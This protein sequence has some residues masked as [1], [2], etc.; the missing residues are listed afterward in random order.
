MRKFSHR[1]GEP[2]GGSLRAIV[3][4]F[5]HHKRTLRFVAIVALSLLYWLQSAPSYD[6]DGLRVLS[7]RSLPAFLMIFRVAFVVVLFAVV[8]L[9]KGYLLSSEEQFAESL[10]KRKHRTLARTL[11]SIQPTP[12]QEAIFLALFL[13]ALLAGG[14]HVRTDL[15]G[16]KGFVLVTWLYE[17]VLRRRHSAST[18][19]QLVCAVA[20][21]LHLAKVLGIHDQNLAHLTLHTTLEFA[22]SL[23]FLPAVCVAVGAASLLL[24]FINFIAKLFFHSRH[25]SRI[26]STPIVFSHPLLWLLLS[27]QDIIVKYLFRA[28]TIASIFICYEQ[29]VRHGQLRSIPPTIGF[30]LV[31]TAGIFL[32]LLG[33]RRSDNAI[34]KQMVLASKTDSLDTL[35][36]CRRQDLQPGMYAL[37]RRGAEVPGTCVVRGLVD[38]N[39]PLSWY[40][41]SRLEFQ[42][43]IVTRIDRTEPGQALIS[44]RL[45]DGESNDKDRYVSSTSLGALL[46]T[47]PSG[48]T[49][50]GTMLSGPRLPD[51]SMFARHINV[52][53]QG[54]Q[55]SHSQRRP[56]WVEFFGFVTPSRMQA[57]PTFV[58]GWLR[59][60]GTSV[61]LGMLALFTLHACV[62]AGYF[63]RPLNWDTLVETFLICQVCIPLSLPAIV[64]TVLSLTQPSGP[65]RY[66][67]A[68]RKAAI[69]FTETRARALQL[70]ERGQRRIKWVHLTDKTGT[71]TQNKMAFLGSIDLRYGRPFRVVESESIENA[72]AVQWHMACTQNT[73]EAPHLVAEE[74]AYST[75]FGVAMTAIARASSGWETH[76]YEWHGSVHTQRRLFLEFSPKHRCVFAL[77]ALENGQY[78]FVAQGSPEAA[79]GQTGLRMRQVAIPNLH[80]AH[81]A[82]HAHWTQ[83]Y[84]IDVKFPDGAQRNWLYMVSEPQLLAGPALAA[85]EAMAQRF[86]EAA[87]VSSLTADADAR[88]SVVES[89]EFTPLRYMLLVDEWRPAASRAANWVAD[90]EGSF[91]IVT[92]DGLANSIAVAR[93][94]QLHDHAHALLSVVSGS[95]ESSCHAFFQELLSLPV[96]RPMTLL[97]GTDHQRM[98]ACYPSLTP[99]TRRAVADILC[100]ADSKGHPLFHVVC[101]ASETHLKGALVQFVASVM[102][103]A[104]V[105]SGD[106]TNDV[107]ALLQAGL[108][109]ALPSSSTL[110]AHTLGPDASGVTVT[111]GEETIHSLVAA[112]AHVHATADF[113]VSYTRSDTREFGLLLWQRLWSATLL[114]AVKQSATAGLVLAAA[115]LTAMES[116]ADPFFPAQYQ[117]FQAVA[118]GLVVLGAL[119]PRPAP[120]ANHPRLTL[121]R[122]AVTMAAAHVWGMLLLFYAT[123]VVPA[124]PLQCCVD[125]ESSL[126]PLV[127]QLTRFPTPRCYP[128]LAPQ[129]TL[130]LIL[131]VA[132]MAIFAVF[133]ARPAL[134][135]TWVQRAPRSRARS[136]LL[137]F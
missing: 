87:D 99:E 107:A 97:L 89:V 101:F 15:I 47:L 115:I 52:L 129:C 136:P 108:A 134:L 137:A 22:H 8:P 72:A 111:Q 125:L 41:P 110:P 104:T 38:E 11:L 27:A 39:V 75:G 4:E 25:P 114:L 116:L 20:L 16:T 35:R 46:H 6:M 122:V 62:L 19:V 32:G 127:E 63:H 45:L 117:M 31:E 3:H 43:R 50:F 44:T 126:V 13:M 123:R 69:G 109:I 79:M 51:D 120:D 64:A 48:L 17:V 93:A 23:A 78:Q 88:D 121:R 9:A 59:L 68:G 103:V 40:D 135:P 91:W 112:A 55:I 58:D 82:A 80:E 131:L 96:G 133:E 12:R 66:G 28:S 24:L 7:S 77:L 53:R 70:N 113:W 83:H 33:K 30:A 118:F 74:H 85:L 76:T 105:M 65:L 57:A 56:V 90:Q 2:E 1:L 71:L 124:E 67:I 106:G 54:A 84:G 10:R 34:N 98:L 49:S 130:A 81:E 14:E 26:M 42:E 5:L 18:I 60:I 73:P 21:E 36:T 119:L 100:A 37:L 61:A 92:G 102:Q 86:R 128:H 95:V 132:S 29:F 94:M